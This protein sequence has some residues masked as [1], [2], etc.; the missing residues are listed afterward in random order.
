MNT[1]PK[2]ERSTPKT[3]KG[4]PWRSVKEMRRERREKKEAKA[5]LTSLTPPPPAVITPVVSTSEY[6][7]P[8]KYLEDPSWRLSH[9]YHIVD[10]DAQRILFQPNW[11]QSQ[12]LSNIWYSNII[13][14][15]RQLGIS[16]L[17]CLLFLD[18]CLFNSNVAAGIIAHTRED[19]E[20][21]FKRIKFAYDNLPPE[22]REIRPA[23][24]ESARELAFN[25][26][27]SLRV[28][29]SMRS[30][31]LQ[32]LHISEF[33]KICAHFPDKALEIITGS[34]NTIGNKQ[35]IFIESTAE[36]RGGHFFDMCKS[37][38]ALKIAKKK[39]TLLDWR[40]H[41]YP[42]HKCADYTLS[43]GQT[44][45]KELD[46]Y[47]ELLRQKGIDLTQGQKNWYYAKL[48]TQKDNM[49]SE[50]PSYPDEAFESSIDGSYYAKW[51]TEA[52]F[53]GRIT[54][55]PW[56]RQ[57]LVHTVW[58]IGYG[59]STAIIFYQIVGQE[60]HVIDH[61]EN[62]GEGLPHYAKF[63]KA[64]PYNYGSHFAPHDIESHEFSSG[65]SRKEVGI[66]LGISFITLPT[67]Q[68]SIDDGIE[69]L[70]GVFPRLW[71]DEKN[72]AYLIKCIE[73]YRKEYDVGL[74]V[75]K[76]R[77]IHD[78]ASHSS[79][80][81]RYLA[82]AVKIHVDAGKSGISDDE[83]ERMYQKYNPLFK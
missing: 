61:Y 43:E 40:F 80:A 66:S 79:D 54:N 11:T 39:L 35:Y 55:V 44:I 29:T 2:V 50:Y 15:A 13:L 16:T 28:G 32:Y 27:S 22:I 25:N 7:K 36:G 42:W 72:T 70:R 30:S 65:L 18:N 19:A 51:V 8:L 24:V 52:R 9:L 34:L 12:V 62:S 75:Y 56:E 6:D 71:F 33:G 73:N 20:H 41:F 46:E 14:K 38:E 47:F 4:K 5:K 77:P 3:Y 67:R 57:S 82:L 63:I 81:G 74:Q 48:V 53:E 17:I 10:K 49:K 59:D 69:A 45:P 76:N 83:A 31:T 37:A 78:W 1:K 58:D 64:K 68:T 23:T 60:I 26:A 21:M